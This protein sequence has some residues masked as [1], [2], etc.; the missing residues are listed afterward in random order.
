MSYIPSKEGDLA[1]YATNFKDVSFANQ[2][3][4]GLTV[5]QFGEIED[6]ANDY[7]TALQDWVTGKLLADGYLVVKN[8]QRAATIEVLRKYGQM[9]LN[10]PAVSNSLKAQLGLTV[11]PTP[12]GPVQ[13][14]TN[15]VATGYQTGEVSIKWDRTGNATS[16]VFSVEAQYL[17]D[18]DWVLLGT[19]TKTRFTSDGHAPG[20]QVKF[21]VT[22][23]RGATEST[24]TAPF[25]LYPGSDSVPLTLEEAA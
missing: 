3:A 25:V 5:A 6:A 18:T 16:T 12:Y 9:I 10:N 15:L 2:A 22:A 4:L 7:A 1:T 8:D 19:T 21:R 14:P 20:D 24:P 23:A 11:T 13:T 17:N